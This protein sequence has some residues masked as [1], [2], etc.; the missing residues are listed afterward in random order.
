MVFSEPIFLF[1]FLP[2]VLLAYFAVPTQAKNAILLIA[3]LVFYAWGEELYILVLLGSIFMNYTVGLRLAQAE[4]TQ[5]LIWLWVGIAANIALLGYFKYTGFVLGSIGIENADAL[6]P[7]LPIGISFF[8]FQALSYLIDLYFGRINVQRS[9]Y[10]LALYI[11]LFPQLIAGP[12][13]RYAEVED[14]IAKRHT[15]K[16]DVSIGVHRFVTGLA[17]KTLLADPLGLL[18]DQIFAIPSDGLSPEIAWIGA[19]AYSLQLYFDFSAYSDMAIG[20]GRIFGFKFPENFNYPYLARSITE[21]WRRW[22]MTLSRWFRDYLYIPL[23]GNRASAGRTYLNLWIVFLAT[24]IWHGA[25]WTFIFWGAFHGAFLILERLG[26]ARILARLPLGLQHAYLLLV[27]IFG[28]VAFRAENFDQMFDFYRAMVL[29]ERGDLAAAYPV[30]RY[31]DLYA[32]LIL[33][34]AAALS[35]ALHP[36]LRARVALPRI[37]AQAWFWILFAITLISVGAASY[38]PFIYFRF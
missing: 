38:S 21:F 27:V 24:G 12:I 4:A 8:T 37:A 1:T 11:S 10:R 32:V 16:S 19:I 6:T 36:W 23:G 30:A 22:H 29:W 20:L 7:A 33:M 15:S 25:A 13:V 2:A 35:V 31:V 14:A 26:L 28:W 3:S 34:V 17:K 9:P 5:R 18:A